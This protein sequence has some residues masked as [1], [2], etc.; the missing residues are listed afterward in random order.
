MAE[1]YHE[2]SRFF[3]KGC[4]N[5]FKKNQDITVELKYHLFHDGITIGHHPDN[6]YNAGSSTYWEN[7]VHLPQE[8]GFF[9]QLVKMASELSLF[10]GA[11]SWKWANIY[12]I[13]GWAEKEKIREPSVWIKASVW[14][15]GGKGSYS[16]TLGAFFKKNLYIHQRFHSF[17]CGTQLLCI[18]YMD[19]N[20]PL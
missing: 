2:P 10:C 4:R 12:F 20:K 15:K 8:V 17:F 14:I 18:Q 6:N 5:Y 1:G 11:W 7:W 13:Q 19:H 3:W 9:T 16:I